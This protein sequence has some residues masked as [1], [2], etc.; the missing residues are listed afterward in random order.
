[1]SIFAGFKSIRRERAALE[2]TRV[3]ITSM[4]EDEKVT[5]AFENVEGDYLEYVSDA[6]LE[7]LIAR[8]PESSGEDEDAEVEKILTSNNELDIDGVLGVEDSP[9]VE[10]D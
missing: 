5:T 4:M 9:G 2:R 10:N 7:D 3:L 6:E 8:L 1:M